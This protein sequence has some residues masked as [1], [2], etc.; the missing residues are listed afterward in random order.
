VYVAPVGIAWID[1]AV[2]RDDLVHDTPKRD[3]ASNISVELSALTSQV[4]LH[5]SFNVTQQLFQLYGGDHHDLD[6]GNGVVILPLASVEEFEDMVQRSRDL[7][8]SVASENGLKLV[9]VR[10]IQSVC[11]NS[12]L[13]SYQD[14]F[15]YPTA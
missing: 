5:F 3:K 10:A 9:L 1:P 2:A 8:K 7:F 11:Q 14:I 6:A 4:G 13:F 15:T 12:N